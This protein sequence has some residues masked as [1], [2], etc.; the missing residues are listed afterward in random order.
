MR[1]DY[2]IRKPIER[3]ACASARV[4]ITNYE[5][6][7]RIRS[8]IA[9]VAVKLMGKLG[10]QREA[11]PRQ[12]IERTAGAPVERQ[13][14]TRL[15]G[16]CARHLRALNDSDIDAAPS[17]KIGGASSD[18]AAAANQNTHFTAPKSLG[19]KLKE[20]MGAR[21]KNQR[22]SGINAT[23][24]ISINAPCRRPATCTAALAGRFAPKRSPRTRLYSPYS[25]RRVSHA[26]MRTT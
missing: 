14:T 4:A 10:V 9:P 2:A 26:V 18:H 23:A 8:A 21:G 17:E 24:S 25:S 19:E 20:C 22:Q 5:T 12:S 7:V 13:K 3:R 6:A 16:R 15:A 1:D 11:A